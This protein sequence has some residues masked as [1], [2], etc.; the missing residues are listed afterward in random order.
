MTELLVG[1][2]KAEIT[3]PVGYPMAGYVRRQG[4]STGVLDPLFV[5]A[6]VLRSGSV[7]VALIIAD[8]LLVSNRWAKQLRGAI[9]QSLRIPKQ[10]VILAA[11]HTHSGPWVDTSPFNFATLG[12][13]PFG[14]YR[15]TLQRRIHQAAHAAKQGAV[16]AE[17]SFGRAWITGV[18]SDR[19][20]PHRN[21]AQSFFLLRFR[22]ATREALLGFY[23][24]HST[25]LGYSNRLFS[26]DLL[27]NIV[28]HL[29]Q[30][31]SFAAVGVGA[32]ANISSRFTR[33]S[34]ATRE[35]DRLARLVAGQALRANFRAGTGSTL[36]IMEK[37]L[38]LPLR[39][40]LEPFSLPRSSCL[41]RRLRE[42]AEE[43]EHNLQQLRGSEEFHGSAVW[44]ELTQIDFGKFSLLACPLEMAFE[45]GESLWKHGRIV[46]WCC[47]N[48]YW[49]Y[50]PSRRA[51]RRDYEVLS[52][53]FSSKA[54]EILRGAILTLKPS[55]LQG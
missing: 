40:L 10:N 53:P 28:R 31:Y 42:V 38:Q 46:P 33:R 32:A 51:S 54:E 35:V 24:C 39:N 45:S 2:A 37:K 11:T 50:L 4:T 12:S 18:A 5:R 49:G 8:L 36:R 9:A 21:L 7:T 22:S 44:I 23:G 26:G 43:A 16:P 55:P 15:A 19:N 17:L 6:F 1:W 29:E 27:G 48:G 47:A 14:S 20:H 41:P 3:P 52:S 25:V 30:R 34:Q 13:R